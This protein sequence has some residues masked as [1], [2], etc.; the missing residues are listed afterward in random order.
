MLQPI[1][2]IDQPTLLEIAANGEFKGLTRRYEKKLGEMRG[3]YKDEDSWRAAV[4]KRGEDDLVYF[5]N[6]QKYQDG[7]GAL[8]VGTS[9]LLP[10]T[11]GEEFA[12]TRGHLHSHADRAELYFCLSGKGV[13]LLDSTDGQSE[14]VELSPGQA[15][16][17]P[18]FWVH[19]SINVGV[20]PF[21]TLFC[22]NADA[23]QNYE[24][25]PEA[26]RMKSLVVR[27][28]DG[29]KTIANPGHLGYFTAGSK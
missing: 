5:V 7:P 23:G 16:N 6:E 28:G 3:V 26:G 12:M 4:Q 18:G 20:E 8:I 17:V 29:W 27:A 22:Y 25:I 1:T 19:R 10:G 21:V 14:A 24:L 9:V 11:I 2:P 15:V 13:M